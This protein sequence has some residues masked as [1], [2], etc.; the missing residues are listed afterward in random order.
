MRMKNRAL[1]VRMLFVLF[2]R[3]AGFEWQLNEKNVYVLDV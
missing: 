3:K 1:T 2:L